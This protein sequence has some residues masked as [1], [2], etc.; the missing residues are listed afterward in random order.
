MSVCHYQDAKNDVIKEF[1]ITRMAR[2]TSLM[3][4]CHDQNGKNECVIDDGE[5]EL[6]EWDE[7]E[8]RKGKVSHE[9][10]HPLRLNLTDDVE[11]ATNKRG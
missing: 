9:R 10:V 5:V 11:P 8:S 1:V 3:R 4:V 2:M 7:D 6:A